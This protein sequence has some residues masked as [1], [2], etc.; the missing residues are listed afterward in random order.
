MSSLGI[1]GG[2]FDP[3]HLGHR[4]VLDTVTRHQNITKLLVVPAYQSP[5]KP[6]THASTDHRIQMCQLG[7][8]DQPK[9]EV[10]DW[11]TRQE[12]P[13]YTIDTV[14]HLQHEFKGFDPILIM[15]SDSASTLSTW[16]RFS[17]LISL[18]S[19]IVVHRDIPDFSPNTVVTQIALEHRHRFTFIEIPPVAITATNIRDRLKSGQSINDLVGPAVA[20]YIRREGLYR[21]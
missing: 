13:S 11:E 21:S 12:S 2:S 16:H 9:W 14:L 17:E 15:G 6:V 7:I 8:Q 10:W 19:V 20:R 4:H 5:L 1:F 3:F 18:I